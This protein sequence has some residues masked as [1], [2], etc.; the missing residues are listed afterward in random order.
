MLRQYLF[1][2][3]KNHLTKQRKPIFYKDE[4]LGESSGN[5]LTTIATLFPLAQASR[6]KN[7]PPVLSKWKSYERIT[8]EGK[9]G[10]RFYTSEG[11]CAKLLPIIAAVYDDRHIREGYLGI[12]ET[13]CDRLPTVCFKIDQ[14]FY[15]S[16]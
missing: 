3:I 15:N 9:H 13:D 14:S 5:I 6:I 10:F 11:T 4:C 1:H 2:R 12:F 7:N 16:E 8:W